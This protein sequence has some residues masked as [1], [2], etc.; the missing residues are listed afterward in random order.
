MRFSKKNNKG[1]FGFFGVV[2]INV[3]YLKIKSNK[4]LYAK[5]DQHRAVCHYGRIVLI[6][7]LAQ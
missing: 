5:L 3:V 4:V 7:I 1:F 6:I 2:Y